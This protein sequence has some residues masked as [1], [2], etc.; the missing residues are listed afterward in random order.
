VH[1]LNKL[2]YGKLWLIASDG[3]ERRGGLDENSQIVKEWLDNNADLKLMRE[4]D[5]LWVFRYEH[6]K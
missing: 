6:R 1:K 5:G 4:F 3:G 2:N